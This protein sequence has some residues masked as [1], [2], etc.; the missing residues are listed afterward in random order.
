MLRQRV[1]TALIMLAVLVAALWSASPTPFFALALAMM[2]AAAWEWARLNGTQGAGALV[3]GAF[4]LAACALTWRAGWATE[5]FAGWWL[6]TA[7]W[8]V[9]GGLM[10]AAGVPGWSRLPASL[11]L[12][13]GLPA[14]WAAW[15]AVVQSRVVGVNYLMSVLSLVAAADIAA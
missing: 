2:A 3:V 11:R 6:V 7:L 14:L 12:A 10:I 8:V 9:L 13:L 15:L 1:I 5:P 4:M